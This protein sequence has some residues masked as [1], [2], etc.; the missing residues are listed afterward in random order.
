MFSLFFRAFSAPLYIMA[1]VGGAAVLCGICK[2]CARW[3]MRDCALIKAILR[4]TGHDK[5]DDFEMMVHVHEATFEKKEAKL[6]TFVRL[7]AGAHTVQTETSSK[8]VFQQFLHILIEQGTTHLVIELLEKTRSERVLAVLKMDIM[9]DILGPKSLAPEQ[10]YHMQQKGKG[11]RNPQIMLTLV[12]DLNDLETG[13]L[14]NNEV[15]WLV[16]QQLKKAKEEGGAEG[17]SEADLLIKACAGPLE[18]FEHLGKIYEVYVAVVGPPN[19]RKFVFGIWNDKNEFDNKHKAIKEVDL[20]RVQSVQADPTRANVFI[21]TY[22]N[23]HRSS[24][25][26]MFR[27]VDRARDVWVDLLQTVTFKAR[28]HKK[29]QKS[30]RITITGKTPSHKSK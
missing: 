1:A 9:K 8:S 12:T 3:R 16:K 17:S 15:G 7:T 27:R 24:Q 25:R 30:Q 26:M 19:S 23:E 14:G 5:Y 18:L 11:V 20:L 6:T 2:C 28:D 29:E 4:I 21:I 10:V 13:F 22:V